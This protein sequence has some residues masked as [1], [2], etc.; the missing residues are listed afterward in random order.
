MPFFTGKSHVSILWQKL[1]VGKLKKS[2]FIIEAFE[3]G[4][5]QSVN[6]R[7]TDYI[8]S[9]ENSAV[10][11]RTVVEQAL[12]NGMR[13]AEVFIS[14][15]GGS[16]LDAQDM[17]LELKKFDSVNITVGALAASAATY[18]LTQFPS[19]AYPESQFMIHKPSLGVYGTTEEIKASLKLLENTE[20][21]Y[22]KAYAQAFGKTEDE[23]DA[24]W[25]ND[26]W[27]TAQ[28]ALDLGLIQN[29]IA[30]DIDW[31]TQTLALLQACGAPKLPK[32]KIKNMD[33]NKI[34][35]AVGLASDAT[36]EQIEAAIKDLKK[37]S[38]TSAALE[39]Q[40]QNMKVQKVKDLVAKAVASKKITADQV[41]T[42]ENLATA[43]YEATA[44]ALGAMPEIKALSGEITD[45]KPLETPQDRKDWTYEDYLEKAPEAF[46]ELMVKDEKKALE[47]FN[48]RK[49]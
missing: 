2:K 37:K 35:A 43:N 16:T 44:S 38:D 7:I 13:K 46:E 15:M 48:K 34:I 8:G 1:K 14:S 21:I 30:A 47:I 33:R 19:S 18:F 36:D 49:I 11:M 32:Q 12:K 9:Y 42:Y 28:E 6:I 39:S 29:I 4:N 20:E 40:L 22:R 23:I 10:E 17:V 3:N 5:T 41:E 25:K 24:M 27:M 45:P 31:D 26:Y